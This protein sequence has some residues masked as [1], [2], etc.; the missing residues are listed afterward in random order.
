MKKKF[1]LTIPA[2]M[3]GK[4]YRHLFPGDSDEHGAILAA[5][6]SASSSGIRLL[7]A[8]LFLATDGV[9]YVPGSRGYRQLT[10]RFIEEVANYCYEKKLCLI[11]VHCHPGGKPDAVQF[12]S[13]DLASH[14]RGYPALRQLTGQHVGAIV[15]AQKAAAADLWTESEVVHLDYVRVIGPQIQTFRP[16]PTT[17]H[18]AI[19]ATYARHALLFGSKGQEVLQ[20]LKVGI[21]G[22]GGGGSLINEWLSRLGVGE[23]VAVDFDKIETSNLSRVVDATHWDAKAWLTQS[24]FPWIAR[25][26]TRLAV[27]KLDVARRV[28]K[29]ANPRIKYSAI[30]GDIL[31]EAVALQLKDLDFIFLA[32]DT[33]ASRNVFNALLHQYLIPGAQVGAKVRVDPETREIVE[34]FSVG[35]IIMPYTNGGCL[36]CNGWIPADRLQ[37]ELASP[38]ERRA[39]NYVEDKEVHQPSVITLNVLS[40]AQVVNDFLM[41]FT[42]L[43]P[44]ELPLPHLF[45][46]VL[47]RQVD[48]LATR[49]KEGCRHCG[50]D[51]KSRSACGDNFELPCRVKS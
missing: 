31:D 16:R 1:S 49:H 11:T 14:R 9:D 25:L 26:G 24:R 48:L 36:V 50:D 29:R 22:L 37:K 13:D 34:I 47:S 46:D 8:R 6:L 43:Y 35:R 51:K 4:L 7:A 19:S 18:A 30:K 17:S 12:S 10:P 44:K 21:I 39:Q 15:F 40:A 32:T 38:E 3:F 33:L 28:A 23:I 41:L 45:H 2:P 20:N 27:H 5:G 42:G